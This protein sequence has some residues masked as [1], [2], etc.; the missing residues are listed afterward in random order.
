MEPDRDIT[1]EGAVGAIVIL[2]GMYL[3]GISKGLFTDFVAMIQGLF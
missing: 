1:E 3:Y 2:I